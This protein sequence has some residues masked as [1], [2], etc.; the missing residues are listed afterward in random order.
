MH[1]YEVIHVTRL[2]TF[3][4]RDNGQHNQTMALLSERKSEEDHESWSAQREK[5]LR[6]SPAI[7]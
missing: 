2:W 5:R 6:E 7:R 1:I 3:A 4:A